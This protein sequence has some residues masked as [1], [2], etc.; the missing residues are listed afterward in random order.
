MSERVIVSCQAAASSVAQDGDPHW[1]ELQQT[2][3]HAE[4]PQPA[5][6]TFLGFNAPAA[7]SSTSQSLKVQIHGCFVCLLLSC[8]W[9]VTTCVSMSYRCV[10]RPGV[11][12]SGNAGEEES[13]LLPQPLS[14][15]VCWKT[16][17]ASVCL[18][19]NISYSSGSS[20]QLKTVYSI[21]K[22]ITVTHHHAHIHK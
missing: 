14:W 4:R 3:E 16:V 19:H 2:E 6:C 9:H 7:L 20:V 5:H 15:S 11:Q 12:T 18:F 13:T 1:K 21:L 10:R 17:S 8:L 22:F